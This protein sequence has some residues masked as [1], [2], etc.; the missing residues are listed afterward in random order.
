MRT[1]NTES[2]ERSAKGSNFKEDDMVLP[3]WKLLLY[4]WWDVCEGSTAKV[5]IIQRI[6]MP[7]LIML[8]N[9]YEFVDARVLTN[10]IVEW[11]ISLI[12]L[13]D[14][15]GDF[16]QYYFLFFFAQARWPRRT[17]SLSAASSPTTTNAPW[18]ST[19]RWCWS[20]CAIPAC[21]RQ[22]A[23]ASS[24]IRC[25]RSTPPLRAATGNTL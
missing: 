17:P 9:N 21:W 22:Y 15:L 19:C 8:S 11:Y 18:S 20:S 12:M 13:E 1:C 14:P 24:A 5:K 25:A 6:L 23:C 3:L 7:L 2:Q 10:S 16:T 4:G